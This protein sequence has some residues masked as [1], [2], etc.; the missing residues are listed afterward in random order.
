MLTIVLFMNLQANPSSKSWPVCHVNDNASL[1]VEILRSI[2]ADG[3]LGYGKNGYYL[4]ASGSVVWDDLYEAI[5]K[6]LAK[7]GVIED[8]SVE[9]ADDAT[10]EKM[11]VALGSPKEY[12]RV[13]LGG[14]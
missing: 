2:L 11:G 1:Y 9:S 3:S 7:R 14:K 5:A 10:L 4:A 6:A 12:V 13:Q 8:A